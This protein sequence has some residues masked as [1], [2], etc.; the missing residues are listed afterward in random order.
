ML[1]ALGVLIPK[2]INL[3]YIQIFWYCVYLMKVIVCTWWMLFKKRPVRTKL[4]TYVFINFY[5]IMHI[6]NTKKIQKCTIV[7]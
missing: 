7:Y 2:D 6:Y 3:F 1:R 5:R 4:D